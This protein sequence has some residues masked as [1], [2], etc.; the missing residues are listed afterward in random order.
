M[1]SALT[2]MLLVS[3]RCIISLNSLCL[4]NY[5]LNS[6]RLPR[7]SCF[8]GGPTF[9][10][11][12]PYSVLSVIF[13]CGRGGGVVSDYSRLVWLTKL[14]PRLLSSDSI[15][16]NI[17]SIHKPPCYSIWVSP[18]KRKT[19]TLLPLVFYLFHAGF[20][21]HPLFSR[22]SRKL[23]GS[24][25]IAHSCIRMLSISTPPKPK[26]M[27]EAK[28]SSRRQ[29]H[30]RSHMPESSAHFRNRKQCSRKLSEPQ[31]KYHESM[32]SRITSNKRWNDHQ[33]DCAKRLEVG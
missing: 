8:T 28:A 7:D 27:P 26:Q 21:A 31:R 24:E 1:S 3:G 20:T 11:F 18:S 10:H 13:Q 33:K 12:P 5:W 32:V 9:R 4:G 2:A 23:H 25:T 30:A 17:L 22:L 16:N 15:N 29:T 19:K 6:D 14:S